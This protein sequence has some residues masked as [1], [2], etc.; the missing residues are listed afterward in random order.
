MIWLILVLILLVLGFVWGRHRRPHGGV[1]Q[2]RVNDGITKMWTDD[3]TMSRRDTH[4][5]D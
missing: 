5:R 1:D 2:R 3:V 4:R